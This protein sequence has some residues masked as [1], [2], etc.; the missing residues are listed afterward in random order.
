MTSCM[1]HAPVRID[2]RSFADGYRMA[3]RRSGIGAATGGAPTISER[4][5][6]RLSSVTGLCQTRVEMKCAAHICFMGASFMGA[7]FIGASGLVAGMSA[8]A[9]SG[10]V[11]PPWRMSRWSI[12]CR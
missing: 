3:A 1:N 10:I 11:D 4:V 5:T 6:G 12:S 9:A 8:G 2:L 7:S